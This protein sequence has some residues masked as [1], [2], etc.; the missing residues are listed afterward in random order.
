MRVDPRGRVP[1][2]DEVRAG[3]VDGGEDRSADHRSHHLSEGKTHHR[4]DRQTD[5][6]GMKIMKIIPLS[7]F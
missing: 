7:C 3:P 1:E 6:D 2:G 4:H 5:F